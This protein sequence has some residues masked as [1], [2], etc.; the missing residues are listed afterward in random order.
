MFC[1]YVQGCCMRAAAAAVSC[2]GLVRA[3]HHEDGAIRMLPSA[4]ERLAGICVPE[5]YGG[6][7]QVRNRRSHPAVPVRVWKSP[8]VKSE[9]ER[10]HICARSWPEVLL[11]ARRASPGCGGERAPLDSIYDTGRLSRSICQTVATASDSSAEPA[12]RTPCPL[13]PR[14]WDFDCVG[15]M[16]M[17]FKPRCFR[18]APG[19]CRLSV[20]SARA[21]P[22]TSHPDPQWFPV[23]VQL[24]Q[25]EESP[26][27]Q[28]LGRGYRRSHDGIFVRP[29]YAPVR[30]SF[31]PGCSTS[32]LAD[33]SFTPA[34]C[35][36]RQ[37]HGFIAVQN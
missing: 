27:G 1:P 7:L 6:R 33:P 9:V 5:S 28:D 30:T 2:H 15:L 36:G 14:C 10:F 35:R 17:R 19:S 3:D 8:D 25:L 16:T 13:L 21:L 31:I 20:R 22:A 4:E 11:A 32:M 37:R 12:V 24:V 34:V 29:P 18:T 23:R 26:R